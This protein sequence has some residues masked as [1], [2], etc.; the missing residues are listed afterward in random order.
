MPQYSNLG[1][2]AGTDRDGTGVLLVNL[3]TPNA[4]TTSA[5]WRYLREFLSDPRVVE[6]PR[7]IWKP[8]LYVILLFRSPGSAGRYRN[9]W[10]SDGSPLLVNTNNLA[11]AVQRDLGDDFLVITAMRYGNPG[12]KQG[13]R[14]LQEN[15]YQN[16]IVIP[17]YPQYSSSTTGSAFDAIAATLTIQRWLPRLTFLTGYHQ[18]TQ[19]IDALANS[20]R[21]HWDN[22][23][24]ADKL[25]ISFHGI[26]QRH[27]ES[28][29]PYARQCATTAE[30][31]ATRLGLD[32]NHW[33]LVYQ[34]RF[35]R[36]EWLTPYCNA[37]L[38][39]LPSAGITSVD[40]LCPGFATDCLET[41][42]EIDRENRE[43]FLAAGGNRVPLHTLP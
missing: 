37:T 33:K 24:K 21:T 16:V 29:D 31:V 30:L 26:P 28:G 19:Y 10:T 13:F 43:V 3:G 40:I 18:E 25:L 41:L 2:N 9:I 4:P 27:I 14:T 39:S 23:G 11:H 32:N 34:S 36:E 1:K 38:A 20:V 7:W 6:L 22:N 17:L 8:L 5:V 12:I 42:D 35:G 15:G